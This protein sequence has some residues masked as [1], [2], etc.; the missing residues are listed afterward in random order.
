MENLGKIWGKLR[1]N[2]GINWRK[3]DVFSRF[4]LSF[5]LGKI[6]LCL[7]CIVLSSSFLWVFPKFLNME[8]NPEKTWGKP[9]QNLGKIKTW[10]KPRENMRKKL[11][12]N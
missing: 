2:P 8:Q 3:E 4:S 10:G 5:S 9:R 12:K 11:E 6:L 7:Q 1:E